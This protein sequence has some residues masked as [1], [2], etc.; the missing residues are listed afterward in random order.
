M[1]IS[2]MFN[3]FL[4]KSYIYASFK[5]HPTTIKWRGK[6]HKR[7]ST[8]LSV[9]NLWVLKISIRKHQLSAKLWILVRVKKRNKLFEIKVMWILHAMLESGAESFVLL[10]WFLVARLCGIFLIE[11][12]WDVI[13][14]F[15]INFILIFWE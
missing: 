1:L 10:F 12:R 11:P 15:W 4:G 13:K 6:L 8:S 5:N 9:C 2:L 3:L 14:T 7:L